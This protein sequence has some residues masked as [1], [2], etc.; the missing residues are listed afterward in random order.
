MTAQPGTLGNARGGTYP[1]GMA[2][3]SVPPE[4][5]ALGPAG[6]GA[7]TASAPLAARLAG[8]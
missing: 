2:N 3:G 8:G 6:E 1:V 4:T 5:V 7:A